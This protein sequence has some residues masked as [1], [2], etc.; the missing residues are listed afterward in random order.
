MINSLMNHDSVLIIPGNT[1]VIPVVA[2]KVFMYD[3]FRL[4]DNLLILTLPDK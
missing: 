2:F 4:M 3:T 1:K